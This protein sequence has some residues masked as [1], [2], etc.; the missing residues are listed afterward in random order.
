MPGYVQDGSLLIWSVG[1]PVSSS[2][3]NACVSTP[4]TFCLASHA[5]LLSLLALVFR[6]SM[7]PSMSLKLLCPGDGS[8]GVS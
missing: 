6:S 1:F 4:S 3:P 7:H 5:S 2:V 8:R